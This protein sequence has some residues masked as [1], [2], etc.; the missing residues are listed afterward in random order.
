MVEIED[1]SI[2]DLNCEGELIPIIPN[3]EYRPCG[4]VATF[5]EAEEVYQ[6]DTSPHQL[7]ESNVIPMIRIIAPIFVTKPA[8]PARA[9]V[10]GP[11]YGRAYR[12][13]QLARLGLEN[14]LRADERDADAPDLKTALQDRPGKD[15]VVFGNPFGEP[16]KGGTAYG[17]VTHWDG[18]MRTG[19]PSLIAFSLDSQCRV[20]RMAAIARLAA[21]VNTIVTGIVD[22]PRHGSHPLLLQRL[23][24]DGR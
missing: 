6:R 13:R 4:Q 23:A 11:I 17:G 15:I 21:Q 9:V 19:R 3:N 22:E 1:G 2:V 20:G 18:P 7:T 16:A 14:P 24:N 5:D 8:V 10:V 12:Q